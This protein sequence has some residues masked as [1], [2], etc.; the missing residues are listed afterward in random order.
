MKR[1]IITIIGAFLVCNLSFAGIVVQNEVDAIGLSY[2]PDEYSFTKV[3]GFDSSLL[4]EFNQKDTETPFHFMTGLGVGLTS[5][6]LN[7]TIPT[8]FEFSLA[9]FEK[10]MLELY[11]N[12]NLGITCL[13]TGY[14][15]FYFNPS[16]DLII[17][18]KNR[19]WIYGGM[20]IGASGT[21]PGC[22][23]GTLGLHFIFGVKFPSW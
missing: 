6:G 13:P 12:P 16:V 22:I 21:T 3:E 5:Y 9:K 10:T 19:N 15:G 14:V 20:G 7:F 18:G 2:Y 11:V 23:V 4:W 1:K 17:S 8:V